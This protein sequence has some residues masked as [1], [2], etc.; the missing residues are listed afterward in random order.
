MATAHKGAISFG[1]VHIPVS[2]YRTVRDHDISFNQLCK[3]TKQR[4]RYKKYCGNCEK[5]LK[6]E[7]IVKG[8]QYEKD[9]YVVMTNDE[10]E[11]IKS[12]KDK[13]IHILQF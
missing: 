12:D 1:L 13:T 8:Y 2:L 3:K 5:E 7:D 9:K 4:V 10:L 11:A 6:P